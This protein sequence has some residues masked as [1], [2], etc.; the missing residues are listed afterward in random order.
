[1]YNQD[2]IECK[3]MNRAIVVDLITFWMA[4][5]SDPPDLNDKGEGGNAWMRTS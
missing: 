3:I 5:L 1:M 2:I 4:G